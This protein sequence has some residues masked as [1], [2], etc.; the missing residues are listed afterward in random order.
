M[1]EVEATCSR[2]V[3]LREGRLAAEGTVQELMASR[4]GG[5]RYV[6]EAEG[7][8]VG[9]TLSSLAGVTGHTVEQLDGRVRVE[10]VSDDAAEL[11]PEIFGVAR[12]NGWTLWEL[13]REEALSAASLRYLNRLSDLLFVMAR[14]ENARAGVDDVEWTGRGR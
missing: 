9:A 13:H 6:V 5:V 8:D 2:L 1:Q 11:R 3:I 12:D 7:R 4:S 10:L 14:I